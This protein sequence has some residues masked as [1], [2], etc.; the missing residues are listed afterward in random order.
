MWVTVVLQH[1]IITAPLS[2][3][4]ESA[5]GLILGLCVGYASALAAC[6]LPWPTL[7]TAGLQTHL[8]SIPLKL[9]E[10]VALLIAQMQV[11]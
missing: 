1:M 3:T 4:Y 7:A 11:N 9:G 2:S 10:L 6:V 8:N 5:V